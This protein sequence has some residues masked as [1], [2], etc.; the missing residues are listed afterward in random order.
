MAERRLLLLPDATTATR[1]NKGGGGGGPSKLGAGRQQER[2]GPRLQELEKAFESKRVQLQTAATGVVPEDVLVLET[3]GTVEEFVKAVSKISGFEFLAEYDELDIPPDEDFF[4]DKKGAHVAYTGRVYMVFTNQD[5]FR[6]LQALWQRFQSGAKFNHGSTKWRDVFALLR[7]IRPWSVKDRLE[8]TGVLTDWAARVQENVEHVHCEIELWFRANAQRRQAA[9]QAVR[10]RVQQ[11]GGMVLSE[12]VVPGIHYHGLAVRIPIAAVQQVLDA[13]TRDQVQLVQSEQIQFFRASGQMAVRAPGERTPSTAAYAGPQPSGP[14]RVALL[15]GLPLQNHSALANRLL[16]DDP[17]SFETDYRVDARAHGTGMASLI[18][19]GDLNSPNRLPI[20]QPLYVRPILRP[21]FPPAWTHNEPYELVPEGTLVVDLV[22][23]SVRRLFEAD[24][25]TAPAAPEVALV[26]FSIGVFDRPFSGTLSPLARLLD[27]LSWTHG[28]L[29]VVSAGNY[30]HEVDT[31]K[32]WSELQALAPQDLTAVIL[33]SIAADTR[34]RRALS[35]AEAMNALTVGALHDDEDTATPV[36]ARLDPVPA[37]YPSPLNAH[38]L[39][40]RRSIKPDLLVPGGRLQFDR[41]IQNQDTRLRPMRIAASPGVQVAAPGAL[42]G[43]RTHTVKSRGTSNAAALLSRAGAFLAP[44]I[45]ELRQGD[46]ATA[47]AAVPDG[48]LIKALL[49]HGARWG[50]LGRNLHGHFAAI[51]NADK[52]TEQ[53]TRLLGFGRIEID[54]VAACSATRVTGVG[55]GTLAGDKGAEHRFPLPPSLSGK[56]GWRRLT[57]TLA[58]FTPVN[59]L[60]Y[61]WRK[62]HLWFETPKSKLR[63][64]RVGPDWQTAQRGTL[65]H[66]TFEGESAAAFVDGED[67]VVRVSCREDAPGLEGVV[68]YAIA[69]TLEVADD[70]GV[71][72]YTEVRERV[73]QRLQVKAGGTP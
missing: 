10:T 7:D 38:G 16:V 68:P 64:N 21:V 40:Y 46:G 54:D 73:R 30:M 69:V 62:A 65:Q 20:P 17:D 49:A 51:D 36:A 43:D 6:Q 47:L 31:G 59:P 45:S 5:A 57:V 42:A 22:H 58:W 23:R 39:G 32:P 9:S 28:V 55:G 71:D 3:A 56:R 35:P 53:V 63:V 52:R 24:G 72:I 67:I 33:Q 48:A 15:D 26:N 4:L 61:R 44:V 18:I 66:D 19:W 14:A 25:N 50:E 2:L 34:N 27:W 41:P 11:L 1:G 8:E 60:S 37:G 13:Q 29:F 12:G 70:I